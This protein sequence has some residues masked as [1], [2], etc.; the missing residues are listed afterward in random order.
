MHSRLELTAILFLNGRVDIDFCEKYIFE[1]YSWL[2]IYCADGAYSKVKNSSLLNKNI[3]KV[4]G[5]FD[6]CKVE[7]NDLFLINHDQNSTDFEKCLE[8]LLD[9]NYT[10]VIVFGGSEGEMDHFLANISV[11]LLYKNKL[12]IEFVDSYSWYFFIPKVFNVENVKGK[13][14]SI[15]PF[16]CVKNIY[17]NGLKYP[18]YGQ[19]LEFGITTGARNCAIENEVSISYSC[20]EILLFISHKKYKDRLDAVL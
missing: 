14:F 13:M 9:Q 18:L 7:S 12:T 15:M 2:P 11:A 6:S 19:D 1:N 17:Y 5:D 16:G 3:K 8:Y 4:I 10:K 20:G